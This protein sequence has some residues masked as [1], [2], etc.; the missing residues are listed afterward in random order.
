LANLSEAWG[1][2]ACTS[3]GVPHLNTI[4]ASTLRVAGTTA[5]ATII[6]TMTDTPTIIIPTTSLALTPRVE[7]RN[8]NSISESLSAAAATT[9]SID[10]IQIRLRAIDSGCRSVF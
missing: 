10:T 9:T 5:N 4:A 1:T 7:L 3:E 6:S 2:L 8:L